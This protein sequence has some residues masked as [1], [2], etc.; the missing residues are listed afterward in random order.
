M[1]DDNIQRRL[2]KT[3]SNH[4]FKT[5]AMVAPKFVRPEMGEKW[6]GVMKGK[7]VRLF[8]SEFKACSS[9]YRVD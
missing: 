3:H 2:W 1:N 5:L 4:R 6:L 9:A 8:A 7:F